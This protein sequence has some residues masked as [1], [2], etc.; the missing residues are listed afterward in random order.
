MTKIRE[1]IQWIEKNGI[2]FTTL[3]IWNR[4]YQPHQAVIFRKTL[5]NQQILIKY[6]IKISTH[7]FHYVGLIKTTQQTEEECLFYITFMIKN[8]LDDPVDQDI[9][10]EDELSDEFKEIEW[11]LNEVFLD[12]IVMYGYQMSSPDFGFYSLSA[13]FHKLEKMILEKRKPTLEEEVRRLMSKYN[14]KK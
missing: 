8:Q 14:Q 4:F 7:I 10:D 13:N 3:I 11:I 2:L 12:D 1:E 6:Y 5:D 9:Q